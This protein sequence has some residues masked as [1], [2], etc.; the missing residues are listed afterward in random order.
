MGEAREEVVLE[1]IGRPVGRGHEAEGGGACARLAEALVFAVAVEHAQQ[2]DLALL[3]EVAEPRLS[4]DLVVRLLRHPFTHHVRE[5]ERIVWLAIGSADSDY[6]GVTPA[7]E[8]ELRDSAESEQADVAEVDRE[9]LAR[10][11]A[12]HGRSPTR[13]A[14]ALNLKNR[15]VLLRLLKKHGLSVGADEGEGS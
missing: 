13:A 1:G 8:A 4:P 7:V 5:L 14:K 10:A 12:E 15:F 2:V 6:I 11:L 9:T 3:R